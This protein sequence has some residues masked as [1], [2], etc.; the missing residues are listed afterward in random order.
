[1]IELRS[2]DKEL[3]SE[4]SDDSIVDS[5]QRAKE[6]AKQGTTYHKIETMSSNQQDS[7]AWGSSA[8]EAGAFNQHP[9]GYWSWQP[10]QNPNQGLKRR[11][12]D[13]IAESNYQQMQY[14]GGGTTGTLA[15]GYTYQ[16]PPQ[17]PLDWD[18][19]NEHFAKH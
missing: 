17:L 1:M 12:H 16:L 11:L 14:Y 6:R 8:S 9:D 18:K 10:I 4:D 3:T 15:N 2:D 7:G 13:G 5:A 19:L